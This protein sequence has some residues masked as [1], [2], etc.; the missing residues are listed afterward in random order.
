M[1]MIFLRK[2]IEEEGEGFIE[3]ISMPAVGQWRVLRGQ[4][5]EVGRNWAFQTPPF[6]MTFLSDPAVSV[7]FISSFCTWFVDAG[8][9]VWPLRTTHAASFSCTQPTWVASHGPSMP[10]ACDGGG[11]IGDAGFRLG[12]LQWEVEHAPLLWQFYLRDRFIYTGVQ[13]NLK[14][15]MLFWRLP[16]KISLR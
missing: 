16:F 9:D 12:K 6:R 3:R 1:Q 2:R 13:I 15:P 4:G 11:G 10:Q 14:S 8:E 5:E 7:A